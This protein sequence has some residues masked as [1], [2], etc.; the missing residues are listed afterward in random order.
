MLVCRGQTS[1]NK[2][3]SLVII[4]H[5]WQSLRQCGLRIAPVHTCAWRDC[6]HCRGGILITPIA[7]AS[8]RCICMSMRGSFGL[9]GAQYPLEPGTLT[10]SPAGDDSSYHL[11]RAGM[12]WCIHFDLPAA[13]LTSPRVAVS[14][15]RALGALQ[16]DAIARVCQHRAPARFGVGNHGTWHAR[17]GAGGGIACVAGVAGVGWD[18]RHPCALRRHRGRVVMGSTGWSI[19]SIATWAVRCGQ[20]GWRHVRG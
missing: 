16:A 10:L 15:V 9:G 13:E 14:L 17:H 12:H 3:I 11:P 4:H 1:G 7:R 18:D 8:T 5:Q 6:F 20:V 19:I 2:S